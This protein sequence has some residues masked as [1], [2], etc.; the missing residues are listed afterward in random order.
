MKTASKPETRLTVAARV[1]SEDIKS[2]DF[3]AVL[4]EIFEFPSFLWSDSTVSLSPE[5]PVRIRYMPCNAGHPFKVVAVCLPFVYVKR[6]GGDVF[7][8]DT[9]Q[10]QLV[11]LDKS[12][13]EKLWRRKGA[14]KKRKRK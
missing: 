9:R 6:H 12:T 14:K 10:H 2:G 11:R 3:V 1:A 7:N 4:N 5:E 13:A 8:F